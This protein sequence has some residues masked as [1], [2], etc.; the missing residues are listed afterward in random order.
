MRRNCF[1]KFSI[2]NVRQGTRVYMHKGNWKSFTE[3]V[4][5]SLPFSNVRGRFS[6]LKSHDAIRIAGS[7]EFLGE[8]RRIVFSLIQNE[9]P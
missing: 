6:S 1:Q 3:E 7:I 5:S 9:I 8:A 2:E 4:C